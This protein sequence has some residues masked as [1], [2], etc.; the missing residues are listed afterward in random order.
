MDSR[1]VS[2]GFRTKR[3]VI[4]AKSRPRVRG[5]INSARMAFP[6]GPECEQR[7]LVCD[8]VH[9]KMKTHNIAIVLYNATV[10]TVPKICTG[11]NRTS[12]ECRLR[13]PRSD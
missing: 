11:K 6:S 7:V 12:A 8:N 4:I 13:S 5:L 2:M 1:A 9:G 3:G 10:R